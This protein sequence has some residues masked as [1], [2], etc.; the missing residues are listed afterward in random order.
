MRPLV[1]GIEE[2]EPSVRYL[3]REPVAVDTLDNVFS[4]FAKAGERNFLKLD[5][6]GYENEV[7]AGAEE[8]LKRF[9][10][11]ISEVSLSHVYEG[12]WLLDEM[13][14]YMLTNGFV[15]FDLADVFRDLSSG[16]LMQVDAL[17]VRKHTSL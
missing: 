11:V 14:S 4:R 10:G 9:D 7:L 5:V 3:T 16:Q 6:Q 1:S 8:S 13:M 2:I 17:F 15:L 12:E